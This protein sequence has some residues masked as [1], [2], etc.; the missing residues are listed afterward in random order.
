MGEIKGEVIKIEIRDENHGKIEHFIL[1]L[2]NPELAQ[3]LYS[4]IGHKYNLIVF[5]EIK[6]GEQKIKDKDWIDMNNEF[7]K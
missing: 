7:F 6:K 5:K 1:P 3:K 2:S 4:I